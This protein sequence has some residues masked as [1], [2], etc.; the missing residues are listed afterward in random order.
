[1]EGADLKA[2]LGLGP[3]S[4]IIEFRRKELPVPKEKGVVAVDFSPRFLLAPPAESAACAF[5][6]AASACGLQ[7]EF[8]C[9]VFLC[10]AGS[11]K[12]FA[13]RLWLALESLGVPSFLDR[14][15]LQGGVEWR[16]EI[17]RQLHAAHLGVVLLDG[18]FLSRDSM[19]PA[20]ESATL[21]QR[22]ANGDNCAVLPI[23]LLGWNP[24]AIPE[25]DDAEEASHLR[26][27]AA[28]LDGLQGLRCPHEDINPHKI[29]LHPA[30]TEIVKQPRVRSTFAEAMRKQPEDVDILLAAQ[31]AHEEADKWDSR[32][33]L[34]STLAELRLEMR[35][36]FIHACVFRRQVPTPSSVPPDGES[37]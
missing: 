9:R 26:L 19:W 11:V 16:S 24:R 37:S 2:L 36:R 22:V 8:P 12:S 5:P 29:N 31:L 34:P 27:V 3:A 14:A 6:A 17:A 23:S 21:L 20:K 25:R 10:H 15:S 18:A 35:E 1:V 32:R 7:S 4:R 28:R 33:A 30:L 13:F